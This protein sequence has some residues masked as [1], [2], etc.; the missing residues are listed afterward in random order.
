[1]KFFLTLAAALAGAG[2]AFLDPALAQDA[3]PAAPIPDKGDTAWMLVSSIPRPAHGRAG[4]C[5][6]LRRPRA[7]QE[8]ALVLTQ[9]FA[10]ASIAA[11][12]WVFY[13]YSLAFTNGGGLNDYVG[14][15]SKAFLSGVDATAVCGDLL[16]RRGH[17]RIRLSVLP[18]DLR[19]DHSRPHRRGLRRAR[20]SSPH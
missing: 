2:L 9:V 10:I 15:L 16:Q 1:M 18:D 5:A 11:L 12:V 4:P 14:G 17:S 8:H 7:H 6:V 3:A 20:G 19:D 13:G